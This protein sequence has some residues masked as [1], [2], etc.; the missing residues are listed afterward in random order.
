[1]TVS[2]RYLERYSGLR[3]RDNLES[4]L[5]CVIQADPRHISY[6]RGADVDGM[7]RI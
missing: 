4:C 5:L 2:F 3:I 7:W 1:M 6:R